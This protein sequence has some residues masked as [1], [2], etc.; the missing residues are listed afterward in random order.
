MNDF[1]LVFDQVVELED[2]QLRGYCSIPMS[3]GI[4]ET[5]FP[6]RPVVPGVLLIDRMEVLAATLLSNQSEGVWTL[7][8]VERARFRRPVQP[9]DRVEVTV[10]SIETGGPRGL[11]AATAKVDTGVA[12]TARLFLT[13]G[14]RGD[15]VERF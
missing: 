6:R 12:A 14:V 9:G 15:A 10:E 3:L 13:R 7:E 2:K 11:V 5:H 8:R 1:E 4:F